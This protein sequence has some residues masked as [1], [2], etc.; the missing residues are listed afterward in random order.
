MSTLVAFYHLIHACNGVQVGLIL[1]Y[2]LIEFYDNLTA[3]G[4]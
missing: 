3:G 4:N 2:K 1:P